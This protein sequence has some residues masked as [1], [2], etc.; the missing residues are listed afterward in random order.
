MVLGLSIG[1]STGSP[2]ALGYVVNCSASADG[3]TWQS[4]QSP[5]VVAWVPDWHELLWWPGCHLLLRCRRVVKLLL[6]LMEL[7][8]VVPELWRTVRLS[9]GW[10][11]N[12]AV[13]Q[14]STARTTSG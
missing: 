14:G 1:S 5:R 9:H 7:L 10:R 13:L 11:V 6:L 4:V 12:H 3:N 2:L 8:A